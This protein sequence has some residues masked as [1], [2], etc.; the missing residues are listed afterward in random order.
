MPIPFAGLRDSRDEDEG[1]APARTSRKAVAALALGL[2]SLPLLFVGLLTGIAAIILAKWSVSEIDRSRGRVRG[3]GMAN[4][5]F[6]L[7][8]FGMIVSGVALLLTP[9]VCN[10]RDA[11][12]RIQSQNNLKQIGLAI[13]NDADTNNGQMV[14]PAMCD[15]DGTPLLSWRVA[16]LPY[17]EQESLYMQFHLDEPW[18]SPHNKKL[19]EKMPKVYAHGAD[20][21][22]NKRGETHYRVFTGPQTP[23]PDA[24]P[25]YEAHRSSGRFPG[26][27]TDGTSMTIL[28]V[29]AAE[30]VPWTKPD[31]LP[32]D[33]NG[34]LPRLGLKPALG[35]KPYFSVVMGD[36]W[37]RSV[38]ARVSDQTLR[39]AITPAGDDYLG[40]DW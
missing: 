15:K 21:D 39:A 17:L 16:I 22:A 29:E 12:T 35:R 1:R 2:L 6:V 20:P 30:A 31:E 3:Y 4:A 28:V 7:G 13:I 5:G 11:A 34:P 33:P 8:I 23:F 19:I 9:A 32:Y 10:V 37:A 36:A 27:F 24:V 18:D 25:P 40:D 38:S 26:S 14:A